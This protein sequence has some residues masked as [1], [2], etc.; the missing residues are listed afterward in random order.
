[1]RRGER[2]GELLSSLT[3]F[4]TASE[5]REALRVMRRFDRGRA[6]GFLG[7]ARAAERSLRK[8]AKRKGG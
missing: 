2:G 6:E 3:L 7:M 1:M 5:R 4:L 8:R